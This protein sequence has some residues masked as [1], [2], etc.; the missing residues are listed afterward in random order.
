MV[1]H[2]M[3]ETALAAALA[4]LPCAQAVAQAAVV[5]L[6]AASLH[7]GKVVVVQRP[8][9]CVH[10]KALVLAAISSLVVS[11]LAELA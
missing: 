1:G 7:L 4:V 11:P 2:T 5:P 6:V 9:L 10:S 8:L 3:E